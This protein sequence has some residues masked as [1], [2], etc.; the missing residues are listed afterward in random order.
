VK[1]TREHLYWFT[2]YCTT[3]FQ[4]GLRSV[5]LTVHLHCLREKHVL[6]MQTDRD[7]CDTE[8]LHILCMH[9]AGPAS[10]ICSAYQPKD[11]M[12]KIV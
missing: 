2:R 5:L 10:G 8:L 7:S 9:I 1:D 11:L 4:A 6:R 3:I 12:D